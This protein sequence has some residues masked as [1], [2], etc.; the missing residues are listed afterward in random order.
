MASLIYALPHFALSWICNKHISES[1]YCIPT[2]RLHHTD[3]HT[4]YPDGQSHI[5]SIIGSPLIQQ[6]VSSDR[7][8]YLTSSR[9]TDET[10]EE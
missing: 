10:I 9:L 4:V 2:D 1:Y 5:L 7:F 8:L 6:G 3:A